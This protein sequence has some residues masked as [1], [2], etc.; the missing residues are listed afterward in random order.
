VGSVSSFGGSPNRQEIGLGDATSILKLENRW[1]APGTT[2]LFTTAE[3][4]S[5]VQITEIQDELMRFD[6]TGITF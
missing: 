2:R 1:P 3:P 5:F 4:D 6:P